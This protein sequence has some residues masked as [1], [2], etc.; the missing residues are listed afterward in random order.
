LKIKA[1]SQVGGR[2]P[3]A[4]LVNQLLD[5]RQ[6]TRFRLLVAFARWSGLHLI[7]GGLQRFVRR[8]HIDAIVG[9]DLGGT[10]VEALTYLHDLP[11][12]ALRV[13]S[14]GRSDAIF[15]PKLYMFDGPSRWAAVVGSAN[16]TTGGLYRNAEASVLLTGTSREPNPFEEFWEQFDLPIEPVKPC[17]VMKVDT[18]VLENLAP[19]LDAFT[20]PAPDT[21]RL[22]LDIP[23]IELAEDPPAPGRPPDVGGTD[24]RRSSDPS[25]IISTTAVAPIGPGALFMELWDETGGG[26]QVQLPKRVFSDF[27]GGAAGAVTYVTLH[28]P[29]GTERVRLQAFA[30]R[31]WRVNLGFVARYP[32]PMRRA[33]LKFVRGS[34][35]EYKVTIR[36][37]KADGYDRWLLKCSEGRPG[38]KRFGM[39]P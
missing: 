2:N 9:I 11:N 6:F 3:H 8:G 4:G 32:T 30:N 10:T 28:T 35:D 29:T 37:Q 39:Y 27:F 24:A 15:H 31:T 12:S 1:V 19:R 33:V 16:L 25:G 13:V 36:L 7:D 26:S 23:A 14:L 34:A 21:G 38:S 5:D 22:P 18:E 17:H 20:E